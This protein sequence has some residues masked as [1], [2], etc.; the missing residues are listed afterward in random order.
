MKTVETKQGVSPKNPWLGLDSFTED[1]CDYFYGRDDEVSELQRRVKRKTLTVLFGQSGLGKTSLLQAGL[2]PRLRRDNF[3]PIYIRLDFAP[4]APGLVAQVKEHIAE[5]LGHGDFADAPVPA[6]GETLWEYF[7]RRGASLQAGDGQAVTPVLAFDQFEEIFTVGH[8]AD[9]A[10]R[11]FL[12]ELSDLVENRAPAELERRMEEEPEVVEQFD[13]SHAGY[14]VLLSLREDY[15]PHLESKS[16]REKMPSLMQNRMRLTRMNGRQALEAVL[17]PGG[18]LVSPEIAQDIVCFVAG[19]RPDGADAGIEHLEVEPSLLSL[20]CREL[21]NKRRALGQSLITADLLA[22]SSNAILQDFYDRSVADQ[23]PPVRCFVEDELLTDSGFRE[24]VALERAR[25]LLEQRG[26]PPNAIDRL[27]DRRLL[28]VEE[29]LNVRRVELTHDILT[30]VVRASRDSRHAREEKTEAERRQ[31]AAEEERRLAEEREQQAK[32]QLRQAQRQMAAIAVLLIVAVIAAVWAVSLKQAAQREQLRAEQER[33]HAEEQ[34][35]R[36][37]EAEK[38]AVENEMFARQNLYTAQIGRIHAAWRDHRIGQAQSLLDTVD[39]RA[40][41]AAEPDLRGWEWYFLKGL[42][43]TGSRRF[44]GHSDYV[45]AVAFSPDGRWI[46]SAS[47]DST[48]KLW[49]AETGEEVRTFGLKGEWGGIG[50]K[51]SRDSQFNLVVTEVFP[52]SPADRQGRL[53]RGDQILGISDTAGNLVDASRRQFSEDLLKGKA[54]SE[55]LIEVLSPGQPEKRSVRMTRAEFKYKSGHQGWVICV[56]FS[57]D[58]KQLATLGYDGTIRLWDVETGDEVHVIQ[59]HQPGFGSLAISPDGHVL[60]SVSYLDPVVRLWDA[61][62]RKIAELPREAHPVRHLSLGKDAR[63]ALGLE[64]GTVVLW[65][66]AS[67]REISRL[68]AGDT[69]NSTAFS[70][71]GRLLAAGGYRAVRVWDLS[72]N[73]K[74]PRTLSGHDSYV[75]ALAFNPSGKRL[76]SAGAEGTVKLWDV[77]TGKEERTLRGHTARASSVAFSPKGWSLVSSAKD[78]TLRLWDLRLSAE[79]GY[80][81]LESA[82]GRVARFSQDGRLLAVANTATGTIYVVDAASTKSLQTIKGSTRWLAFAP[83]GYQLAAAEGDGTIKLID[84]GSG[85]VLRSLNPHEGAVSIVAYSPDGKS[86]ASA[87]QDNTVKLWDLEA[88]QPRTLAGH[89][90][91]VWALAFSPDGKRLA[92]YAEDDTV[93]IWDTQTGKENQSFGSNGS[94]CL[95]FNPSGMLLVTAEADGRVRLWD[96]KKQVFVQTL[97]GHTTWIRDAAFSPDSRRLVTVGDDGSVRVWDLGTGRELFTLDEDIDVCMS[98]AFS[99]D[100]WRLA[101]AGDGG[102]K[103]WDAAMLAVEVEPEDWVF[104]FS[105]SFLRSLNRQWEQCAAELSRAIALGGAIPA[106]WLQRAHA[107]AE[108]GRWERA[109]ADIATAIERGFDAVDGNYYRARLALA[110]SDPAD[111]Q[112]ACAAIVKVAIQRDDPSA[113]NQAAWT[114]AL[115][116]GSDDDLKQALQLMQ[117]AVELSPETWEYRNTFGATLYRAGQ[118]EA[119]IEQLTESMRMQSVESS[120]LESTEEAAASRTAF[121]WLFLAMA[122]Q[123]LG[124]REEA[125]KWLNRAIR[126]MEHSEYE[127]SMEAAFFWDERLE[128]Q[129]LRREA[130]SLIAPRAE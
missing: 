128:M 3:L 27:V 65:D 99:S 101:T 71:D 124:H 83:S 121:D 30:G 67:N 12:T 93:R 123:R 106:L 77:S 91:P 20:V 7:H 95:K 48:A 36:A 43:D 28:R 90:A 117:R 115:A 94:F 78:G 61:G 63:L 108:L 59:A 16:I 122:H 72:A 34:R 100:G 88:G 47:G 81:S 35:L 49:D 127:R 22:G 38:R 98:V 92:S 119:A 39:V 114:C 73:D 5:A 45:N 87:G 33:K 14:R 74:Q 18:E 9:P 17:K 102:V 25:K 44:I 113:F 24:N 41:S 11:L 109:E 4:E 66:V 84:A 68:K 15:L 107:E 75:D 23:P 29:R 32:K 53:K 111:F 89:T 82:R 50:I 116:P 8:G 130:E 1:A 56:V 21:N 104:S 120:A 13:F 110:R 86:V 76:A 58:G 51:L 60:A 64:D 19:A 69:V 118:H 129:L 79:N 57:V 125:R 26:A 55:V 31:R 85:R 96:V 112:T 46:A 37:Q 97:F 42:C 105:R 6:V 80:R 10:S 103:L 70:P 62:G 2:F 126:S 40:Q 52:G 54:G